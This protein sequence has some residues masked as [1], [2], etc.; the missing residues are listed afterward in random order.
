VVVYDDDDTFLGSLMADA[1][2]YR[3]CRYRPKRW[4]ITMNNKYVRIWKEAAVLCFKI[5]SWHELG[6]N[7]E[8]HQKYNHRII[9]NLSKIRR[10]HLY[11]DLLG[12]MNT[13]LNTSQTERRDRVVNTPASCS[14]GPGFKSRPGNLLS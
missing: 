9:G 2:N 11:I 3:G 12:Q 10:T 7:E 13:F 4:E 1:S 6:E 14:G 5:L 8:N